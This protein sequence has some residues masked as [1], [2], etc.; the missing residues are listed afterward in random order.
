MNLMAHLNNKK[1]NAAGKAMARHDVFIGSFLEMLSGRRTDQAERA[2]SIIAKSPASP[3][4][5]AVVARC[6]DLARRNVQL[7]AIFAEL[8]PDGLF[9][10][11]AGKLAPLCGAD[12]RDSIRWARNACLRD[13]HE[14]LILGTSMCW[15]GDCMR[16]EPGKVDA[17][18]LYESDAPKVVRLG[19]LAF[20][21]IWG[22]SEA[23]PPARFHLAAARPSASFGAQ[24]KG[25]LAAF[26]FLRKTERTNP[27]A[28]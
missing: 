28:H 7:T 8:G 12:T 16:R 9:A 4:V 10:E 15:S 11:Y 26:S 5:A 27:L 19:T 1:A 2:I 14:Q 18:D 17:L 20:D 23:I 3:V 25:R 6:D 21:A 24:D 13:A 22:I